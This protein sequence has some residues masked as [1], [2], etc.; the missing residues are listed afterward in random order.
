MLTLFTSAKA[1][2]GRNAV[3]QRNALR[4]W[5][6]LHP[7]VQI[8]LFGDEEGSQ[9]VAWE[10]GIHY[11]EHPQLTASGSIRLDYMFATAQRRGRY[12]TLCY[13][14]CDTVLLPDFCDAL[15]RV[16]ALYGEFLMVGR[17][18]ELNLNT[19]RPFDNC[20]W[21]QLLLERPLLESRQT[22]LDR[23][24]YMAF[25]KN[26]CLVNIP[27]LAIESPICLKWLVGKALTD[28]IMVVD[29]SD[30]VTAIRQ[31]C[32]APGSV[33]AGVETRATRTKALEE[34]L[35]L[36][37]RYRSLR[38]V[39]N[40]PYRLTAIDVVRNRRWPWRRWQT[41]GAHWTSRAL[42]AWQDTVW[43]L[44]KLIG[45]SAQRWRKEYAVR[46]RRDG[47]GKRAETV[48]VLTN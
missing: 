9:E 25:S 23:T 21:H 30:M 40:A 6:L 29:T 27:Q 1:F 22:S 45:S 43:L 39:A 18:Q 38:T 28:G 48:T 42:V 13:V 15:N 14:P 10:L 41:R 24:A 12:N 46:V 32:S 19:P 36:C 37:G 26:T 31:H 35:A 20:D 11:E 3:I 7:A 44:K 5:M 17:S 2:R 16:E 33:G 47:H 8:I 34:S 4:S